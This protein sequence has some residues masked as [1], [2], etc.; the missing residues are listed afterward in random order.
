LPRGRFSQGFVDRDR[1]S[2]IALYQDNGFRDVKVTFNLT[3]NFLG[4]RGDLAVTVLVD[5]GPQ[6]KVAS[7]DVEGV[8]RSLHDRAFRMLASTPGEPYSRTSVALDRDF[9]LNLYQSEG[10]T[11][12]S[13][14]WRQSPGKEP[15]TVNLVYTVNPGPRRFVRDVLIS[16]VR[17]T[18]PRLIRPNITLKPGQPLSWIAMGDMERRLY[19][20]GVFENVDMAIQNSDGDTED[21]YVLFHVT[22]GPRY[23]TAIGFG[24]ELTRIGGSPTNLSAPSGQTGFAPEGSFLLSRLN[25]WGLG[26]SLNLQTS[27]STIDQ[28]ASLTYVIPNYRNVQGLDLS[29][30]GLFDNERY[31]NTFT[32]Y[33]VGGGVQLSQRVSKSIHMLWQYNWRHVVVNPSTL[34]INPELIPLESQAA[35][36]GMFSATFIQD[37]RDNPVDAHRGYYNSV[38]LGL[39]ETVFGGNKDFTRFLG[40]NSFYIPVFGASV[41]AVNTQFGWIHPFGVPAGETAFDYMPLPERFF[42]GGTNSMRGFPD[43]QAGPRDLETGFPI[44][45]NAL[46]F[47]QD[48]FRFPLLGPNIGGVLFHDMGNIYTDVGSISFSVHQNSI[49]DFNYMVHAVGFGIR[50]NPHRSGPRRSGL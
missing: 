34:K 6:Y 7:L 3:P 35:K 12:V 10:Y 1:D 24:A 19:N 38:N 13:F 30:S 17:H 8:E 22:E 45:G 4:R 15:R 9:L 11:D 43:F 40:R 18:S 37:H 25:L 26:H 39:A 5:E 20:L 33:R 36:I 41:F 27:F 50:Y 28:Q 49:S 46:L 48:E 21:K 23:Y 29:F 47:H 44:G 2:I 14:E 31:I 42:G 16:G 32:G